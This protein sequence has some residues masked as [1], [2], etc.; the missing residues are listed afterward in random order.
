MWIDQ[1]A[2]PFEFET[3]FSKLFYIYIKTENTII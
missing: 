2:I 1:K 3:P